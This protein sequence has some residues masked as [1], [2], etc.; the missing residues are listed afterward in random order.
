MEPEHVIAGGADWNE[1]AVDVD[2]LDLDTVNE[3]DTGT[4]SLKLVC[5]ACACDTH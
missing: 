4:L 3:G 5:L 1:A 2:N